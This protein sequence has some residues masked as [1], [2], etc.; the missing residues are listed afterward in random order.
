MSDSI[1]TNLTIQPVSNVL[2]TVAFKHQ[3]LSD[4]WNSRIKNW[5]QYTTILHQSVR[6][7]NTS[8]F[9][10]RLFSQDPLL[11]FEWLAV[12]DTHIHTDIQRQ[13][14]LLGIARNGLF[15]HPLLLLHELLFSV[16]LT[17]FSS[18]PSWDL[19]QW[20]NNVLYLNRSTFI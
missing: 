11:R 17:C 7:P 5:I 16:Y 18:S 6:L 12:R 9:Y 1:A 10:S 8:H 2:P 13:H 20:L 3:I 19:T 4:D 15:R 14:I